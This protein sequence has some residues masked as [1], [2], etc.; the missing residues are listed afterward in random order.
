M[1]TTH[2][3]TVVAA[4]DQRGQAEV[5][6]D[7]LWH[8]GFPHDHIGI[9]IPGKGE[10]EA[11]TPEGRVEDRAASGAVTGAVAGGGLGALAGAIMTG[12]IPGIGPVVAGGLLTG[13][14]TGGLAGAAGGTY[15][16]PFIAL[17]LTEA[18]ARF[19]HERVQSGRTIVVV[20]AGDRVV[21]AVAILRNCGGHDINQGLPKFSTQPD[22]R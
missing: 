5:A 13:I 19:Y 11:Q 6:L 8:A 3:S 9:L 21:D 12:L 10:V 7:K 2:S 17:G 4:F 1:T 16:G 20:H 18:D 22:A 14:I 15:L